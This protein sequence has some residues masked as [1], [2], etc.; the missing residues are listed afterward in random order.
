M[1]GSTRTR[2]LETPCHT[3]HK[4][5]G[6]IRHVMHLNKKRGMSHW[7]ENHHGFRINL[8][9]PSFPTVI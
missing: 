2:G 9:C 8:E 1:C 5:G 7:T 6:G 3:M 4:G